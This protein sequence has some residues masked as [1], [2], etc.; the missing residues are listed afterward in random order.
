MPHPVSPEIDHH[1]GIA[2]A[3]AVIAGDHPRGDELVAFIAVMGMPE[4]RQRVR[5][6]G[7]PACRRHDGGKGL[8][9]A[10]PAPV[11]VHRPVAA[12]QRAESD[13]AGKRGKKGR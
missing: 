8:G 2:I 12:G 5:R 3:H 4:R 1:Q 13:I 7:M 11:T 6:G 9:G 10:F